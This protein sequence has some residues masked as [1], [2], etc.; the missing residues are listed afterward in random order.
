VGSVRHLLREGS[1]TY[2]SAYFYPHHLLADGLDHPQLLPALAPRP[3][4]LCAATQDPG[5]PMSGVEAFAAAAR[6]EYRAHHAEH[7]FDLLVETGGHAMTL[8]GLEHF[9]AFLTAQLPAP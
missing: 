4:L 8:A 9:H 6:Q 1:P 3:L 2:H 5:M 7:H